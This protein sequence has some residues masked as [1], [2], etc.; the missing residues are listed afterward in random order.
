MTMNSRPSN[1]TSN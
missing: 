1:N